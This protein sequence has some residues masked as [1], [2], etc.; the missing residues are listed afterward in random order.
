MI[1]TMNPI[2]GR[3]A[4]TQNAVMNM[5]P[6]VCVTGFWCHGRKPFI[7]EPTVRLHP[8][9]RTKSRILKGAEIIARR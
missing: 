8:S 3:G 7:E 6:T 9:T 5:E 1:P 4:L 2:A